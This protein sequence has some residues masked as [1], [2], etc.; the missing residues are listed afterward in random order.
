MTGPFQG[1]VAGASGST[2]RVEGGSAALGGTRSTGGSAGTAQGGA[3]GSAEVGTAGTAGGMVGPG[4]GGTGGTVNIGEK[5]PPCVAPPHPS[6]R[7]SGPCGCGPYECPTPEGPPGEPLAGADCRGPVEADG[8]HVYYTQAGSLHRIGVDATEPERLMDQP[9]SPRSLL[10]DGTGIYTAHFSGVSRSDKTGSSPRLLA[11]VRDAVSV[12]VGGGFAFFTV[13]NQGDMHRVA[14]DATGTSSERIA[15]HSPHAFVTAADDTHVYWVA[16]PDLLRATHSGDTTETLVG[17]ASG[18]GLVLDSS[19]VYWIGRDGILAMPKGGGAPRLLIGANA[20]G[21]A[22]DGAHVYWT[23]SSA[24]I[25]R[26]PVEGGAAEVV[27]GDGFETGPDLALDANHV[28]WL[29]C[30]GNSSTL[31]TLRRIAK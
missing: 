20:Q 2:S 24:Q 5:C 17:D 28:Y 25:K 6:C 8:E 30:A 27:A 13:V 7:G 26:I 16:G 15:E 9:Q 12:A 23:E 4:T 22:T 19:N 18:A 31:A 14:L 21:I 11:S 29:S 10:V 3:A 1:G